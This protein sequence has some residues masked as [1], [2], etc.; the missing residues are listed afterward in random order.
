MITWVI[1][2]LALV[3]T[4]S[5]L[6]ILNPASG[7]SP[8]GGA[9]ATTTKP[10]TATPV[11]VQ[12]VTVAAVVDGRTITGSDGEQLVVEGLGQ[13][14]QCWAE[15]ALDFARIT[16]LGKRV[17]VDADVVRLP[18]GD[19]F[20]VLMA[21]RG[22][23]RR[24]AGA[25]TA[26]SEAQEMAK[27]ANLGLW[28]APCSGSDVPPPPPVETTVPP[29]PPPPPPPATTQPPTTTTPPPVYYANCFEAAKAHAIPL[30]AGQPGYRRELD[31][32]G[33]GIACDQQWG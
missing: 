25:R 23:A 20:A 8:L 4:L 13:P 5:I 18:D 6:A 12:F 26:I 33:N 10:Q 22:L 21:S 14:G 15:A 32:N 29:P 3:F 28:G 27:R 1:V 9:A 16:L 31:P 30:Y 2:F 11:A 24:K 19:D 7:Q 17:Q